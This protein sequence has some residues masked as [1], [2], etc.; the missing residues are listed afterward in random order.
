M[1]ARGENSNSNSSIASTTAASGVPN[2]AAMPAAAPHA[3]R[4][5]R[6]LAETWMSWPTSDPIAPPVTMIGPSAPNGPPVP[7]ATAAESGFAM[8]VRGA[9]LLRRVST[10]SIASG[11]PWP[12]MIGDHFASNV[13]TAPPAI[14]VSTTSGPMSSV[15]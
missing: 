10:A 12:R 2:V 4:I 3:S 1:N 13:T 14:A 15:A 8:A 9:T 6:S 5:L 11:M 7:I